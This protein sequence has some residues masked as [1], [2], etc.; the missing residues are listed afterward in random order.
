MI[1]WVLILSV[2]G[3]VCLA[4]G[5]WVGMWILSPSTELHGCDWVG[6][7]LYCPSAYPTKNT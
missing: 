2:I 3:L 1:R 7:T 5:F 6:K 4:I